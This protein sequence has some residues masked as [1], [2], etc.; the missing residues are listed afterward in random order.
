MYLLYDTFIVIY[1]CREFKRLGRY[2]L[3][4]KN[5]RLNDISVAITSVIIPSV[6]MLIVIMTG[7]FMVTITSV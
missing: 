3:S 7:V 2:D 6:F 5:T 1:Y 4:Y